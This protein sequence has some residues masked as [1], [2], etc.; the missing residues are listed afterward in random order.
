MGGTLNASILSMDAAAEPG[1][2]L[3][4]VNNSEGRLMLSVDASK[5][6][7]QAELTEEDK[8]SIENGYNVK[9]ILSVSRNESALPDSA[10]AKIVIS[11]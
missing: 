8:A 5:E 1:D 6:T 11:L 2:V 3:W 9:F 7:L 10:K 4:D